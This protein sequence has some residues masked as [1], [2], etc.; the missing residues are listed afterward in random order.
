M[1]KYLKSLKIKKLFP[2]FN[3]FVNI[4][5]ISRSILRKFKIK[6]NNHNI[7]RLLKHRPLDRVPVINLSID[8]QGIDS[9]QKYLILLN[10]FKGSIEH[11]EVKNADFKSYNEFYDFFINIPNL[12]TLSLEKCKIRFIGNEIFPQIPYL[13]SMFFEK[14]NDNIF[15]TLQNQA[16]VRTITIRNDDWTWNGFPH[17][18]FNQMA[19][20]SK[21]LKKIVFIG[22]GT[23]SFFDSDDISFKIEILDTTMITFHWYVGIKNGRVS[24]LKSQ[25]GH[26]KELT[27]HKLPFDFDGGKVLKYIIEEMNL[28][29]FYYGKIPLILNGR[30][31]DVKDFEA[32]EIQITSTYEMFRQFPSEYY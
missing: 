10:K 16:S 26:L 18:I 24:F 12:E 20:N 28:D 8:L 31:Q 2:I 27:I 29:K 9:I 5:Q 11:F 22:S 25:L 15:K 7:D 3:R 32:N 23:G 19:I 17:E 4:F 1:H 13:E 6:V 14:C 21:K 30:K